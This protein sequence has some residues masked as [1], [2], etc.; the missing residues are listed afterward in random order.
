[1]IKL[2]YDEIVAKL[3]EKSNLTSEEI[4][5]KIK[6]KMEQLSGLISKEGAAHII[7]NELGIN[8]FECYTL[9]IYDIFV[10][11]GNPKIH[12]TFFRAC[13]SIWKVLSGHYGNV[14]IDIC[15]PFSLKVSA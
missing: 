4:A 15:Q 11:Q 7:A 3:N 13:V 14:R 12:E 2:P 10:P 8:L 9:L 1:M 6:L 5:S